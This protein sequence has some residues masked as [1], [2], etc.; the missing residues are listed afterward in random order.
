MTHIERM[1][2]ELKELNERIG[3]GTEF[4]DKEIEKPNFTDE[5]QRIMLACQIKYMEDYALVLK[6]RIE[7]DKQKI[8]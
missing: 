4:L 6:E 8:K 5:T 3:K 1:E 2:L 7:Y